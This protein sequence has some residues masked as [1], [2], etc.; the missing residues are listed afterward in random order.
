MKKDFFLITLILICSACATKTEKQFNELVLE[1]KCEEATLNIPSLSFKKIS[2]DLKTYSGTFASY[3]LSGSAYG[4]D[5]IFFV[6]GGLVLPTLACVPVVA[7]SHPFETALG[8]PIS[9]SEGDRCFEDVYNSTQSSDVFGNRLS[10]GSKVFEK[11]KKWR[12]PDVEYLSSF[13]LSISNCYS[14]KLDNLKARDQIM[15]IL[16]FKKSQ[17]CLDKVSRDELI[18]LYDQLSISPKT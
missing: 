6:A 9:A 18:N 7:L 14:N 4:A 8:A 15:N 17:G 16:H 1:G 2:A 11:T 13:L 10:L 3:A 5:T 12:C